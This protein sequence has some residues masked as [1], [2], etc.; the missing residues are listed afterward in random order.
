MKNLLGLQGLKSAENSVSRSSVEYDDRRL[1][2]TLNNA[3][4][5]AAKKEEKNLNQSR[6]SRKSMKSMS[7][8]KSWQD[9]QKSYIDNGLTPIKVNMPG[10]NKAKLERVVYAP[11]F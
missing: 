8:Y 2:S 9:I 4:T 1:K 7:A 5:N 10:F 3:N 6:T 11:R